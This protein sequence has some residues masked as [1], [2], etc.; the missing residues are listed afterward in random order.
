MKNLIKL[1]SIA[2]LAC[3]AQLAAAEFAVIVNPA[4]TDSLDI[5]VV[6][7]LFLGK[8]S[9]FANG[10]QAVCFDQPEGSAT[11]D[12]FNAKV[13]DRSASQL[14]A[15][16]AKLVFTGKGTPPEA[17]ADDAAVI[18][19]VSSNPNGIGYVNNASVDDSVK[20]LFTF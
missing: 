16:W 7:R 18:A 19:A 8:Q 4:N 20:V 6:K 12:E 15:Y 1:G 3:M 13:L 11:V 5:G 14:K 10:A 17:L 2:L 9:S